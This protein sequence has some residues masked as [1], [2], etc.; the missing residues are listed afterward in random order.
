M[1]V[2]SRRTWFLPTGGQEI[3]VLR[4]KAF[5]FL[6]ALALIVVARPAELPAGWS[7]V[8][9]FLSF[10][11]ASEDYLDAASNPIA[12][13]AVDLG[14]STIQLVDGAELDVTLES[15]A[16]DGTMRGSKVPEGL[17]IRDI[18]SLRTVRQ[19]NSDAANNST[20]YLV[21]GGLLRVSDPLITD[22]MVSFRSGSG[23]KELSLQ[24]IR[25]IVWSTSPVVENTLK[26]PSRKND[27][28]IVATS[29]GERGVEGIL[30]GIDAEFV[31]IN[32]KGKSQKIGLPK[33]KAVVTAD[34]GMA[35]MD[36]PTA[37]VQLVDGSKIIGAIVEVVEGKLTLNAATGASIDLST[38]NVVSI[39]IVSDRLLY[40]S[41]ADPI[42]VQEKAI[43]TV[44]RNWKRD[45]SI[46]NNPLTIRQAGSEKT[47][48]FKKGLGTQA[49]SRMVFANTN[50]FDRFGA[51]VGIDAE[52]KGRGDCQMV[53]RGDGIELWSKRIRGSEGPQEIDVDITG[54]KEVELLVY[55]GEE[56]DL[57]DHADWGDARFLK[58]K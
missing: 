1:K 30:E 14:K 45:R 39:T 2:K 15:V 37:T 56:F 25:A 53:V 52:T 33:V 10:V 13:E 35:K 42:D 17:N 7:P 8:E 19:T 28:V 24:S 43:F 58:T 12:G 9:C 16:R 48:S 38:S 49:S 46:A 22:E 26:A 50:D 32:Y 36:G 18:L 11:S 34:L 31:R 3:A 21:G 29:A 47:V 55:P 41:D 44:Q 4:S 40:L 51:I 27:T 23:V 57:G 6:M 20:I 5:V 54:M